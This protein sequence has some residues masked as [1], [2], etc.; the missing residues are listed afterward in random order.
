MDR[1]TKF[2]IIPSLLFVFISGCNHAMSTSIAPSFISTSP[3]PFPSAEKTSIPTTTAT[4]TPSPTPTL[5]FD[6]FLTTVYVPPQSWNPEELEY[7]VDFHKLPSGAYMILKEYDNNPRQWKFSLF[8]IKEKKLYDFLRV[9]GNNGNEPP[10]ID[11]AFLGKYMF[12]KLGADFGILDLSSGQSQK[13]MQGPSTE[14]TWSINPILGGD[15]VAYSQYM[16]RSLQQKFYSVNTRTLTT[17]ANIT[18]VNGCSDPGRFCIVVQNFN[19]IPQL[20][21]YQV[22][23]AQLTLIGNWCDTNEK[24]QSCQNPKYSWVP[25]FSP[26]GRLT[27][28]TNYDPDGSNPDL[29]VSLI[30]TDCLLANHW[31][32]DVCIEKK[33]ISFL[34]PKINTR[35]CFSGIEWVGSSEDMLF[36]VFGDSRMPYQTC[37]RAGTWLLTTAG[38]RTKVKDPPAGY[39][40]WLPDNQWLVWRGLSTSAWG[41]YSPFSGGQIQELGN[42]EGDPSGLISVEGGIPTALE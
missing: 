32:F 36:E 7:P 34:F 27:Y 18:S 21:S 40:Y 42:V 19:G 4:T 20:L 13:I 15:A 6:I 17:L 25:T 30:D 9:L 31:N 38:T 33:G 8:S 29:T 16:E 10:W 41:L 2:W 35:G 23:D 3:R 14:M 24:Y 1:K 11:S 5:P 39:R 12:Y 26:D 28:T 22:D 37:G